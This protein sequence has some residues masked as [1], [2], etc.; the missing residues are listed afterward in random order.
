MIKKPFKDTAYLSE[1]K[2]E[3]TYYRKELGS[4]VRDGIGRLSK[5]ERHVVLRRFEFINGERNTLEVISREL[6]LTKERV[7]Q[8]ELR[9]K[10]RLRE[11]F[12]EGDHGARLV[13]GTLW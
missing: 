10:K 1:N 8:I 6:G 11:W 13:D 2:V 5:K 3:D 12:K 9:A 4:L 7:R